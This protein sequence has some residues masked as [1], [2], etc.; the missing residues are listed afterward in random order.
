MEYYTKMSHFK[1]RY[2]KF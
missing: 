1:Y 2:R